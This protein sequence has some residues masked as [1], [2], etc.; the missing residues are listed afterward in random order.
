MATAIARGIGR[1]Q[2]RCRDGRAQRNGQQ[3]GVRL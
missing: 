2:L 1:L 3:R